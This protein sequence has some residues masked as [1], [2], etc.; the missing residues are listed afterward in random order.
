MQ[1][2]HL[3]G[4]IECHAADRAVEIRGRFQ[5]TMLVALAVNAGRPVTTNS[6]MNELWG[7]DLPDNAENALQ[8]HI[9]RLRRKLGGCGRSGTAAA[10]VNIPFGYRLSVGPEQIDAEVF[11]REINELRST[12]GLAPA[13]LTGRLRAALTLWRGDIFGGEIGGFICQAAAIRYEEHRSL[14]LE[15]L[16]EHELNAGRHAVVVAE[17]SQFVESVSVNEKLC[18]LLMVALYRSGRQTDAL[19]LYRR[20]RTRLDEELGIEP[21]AI[22]GRCELA[23]LSHDPMLDAAPTRQLVNSFR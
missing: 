2:Y 12:P 6:L 23:I 22:M 4:A 3:L 13:E 14:A 19:A 8:A 7:E 9:S 20:V 16:Y 11:V 15:L 1:S 21:S 5:R 10:I 18:A 17:L